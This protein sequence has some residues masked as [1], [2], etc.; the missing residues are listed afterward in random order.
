MKSKWSMQRLSLRGT[1]VF[2]VG[3]SLASLAIVGGLGWWKGQ[4]GQSSLALVWDEQ[5]PMKEDLSSSQVAFQTMRSEILTHLLYDD[6]EMHKSLGKAVDS[7]IQV[8]NQRNQSRLVRTQDT[9]FL[10]VL[11][12]E[13]KIL[14]DLQPAYQAINTQFV[15]GEKEAAIADFYMTLQPLT[16]ELDSLID[17]QGKIVTVQ[18]GEARSSTESRLSQSSV[19]ITLIS[20][21][22]FVVLGLFGVVATRVILRRIGGE[23][24]EVAE[25][26]QEIAKGRLNVKV[27]EN[28]ASE[29]ILGAMQEML[30]QLQMVFRE[31]RERAESLNSASTEIQ[32]TSDA[33]SQ[34]ATK[35]AEGVD[36][37]SSTIE[38]LE[39]T[40]R[41]S[42]E[43]ARIT[44][45]FASESALKAS[46]GEK[47]SSETAR[48]MEEIAQKIAIIDEIAYQTNLLALNAAIE[49]A[50]AGDSGRGF[51]V[52]AQEVRKLAER[53]QSA[54]REIVG[55]TQEGLERAQHSG[56]ILSELLPT[57]RKTAELVEEITHSSSEQA[58]GFGHITQATMQLSNNAQA[59]A[60]A[61]EELAAT[62]A[63]LLD[64]SKGLYQKISYFKI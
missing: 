8:L 16:Q 24:S 9:V 48:K 56:K 45:Q 15:Q 42:A 54:A 17:Q 35:Q 30:V 14:A 52:V 18:V 51:A 27:R 62:A 3:I 32:S 58:Q 41:L 44:N 53:S 26:A 4:I 23:P 22:V 47:A 7:L 59:T 28:V 36:V 31:I 5:V 39:A 38:E 6:A 46:E 11:K 12:Q 25:I 40:T 13:Q 55:L 49:A 60:A 2:L 19:A 57:F 64:D 20:V 33:L 43:N 1:M 10:G 34:G 29:S 21:F 37:T 61:A 63:V 50:R